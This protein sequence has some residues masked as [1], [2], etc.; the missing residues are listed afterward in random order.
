MR[1]A[2]VAFMMPYH[3]APTVPRRCQVRRFARVALFQRS[4]CLPVRSSI[5]GDVLVR[6]RL[7]VHLDAWSRLRHAQC[8]CF[9][10]FRSVSILTLAC[11]S[12]DTLS[13]CA[14]FQGVSCLCQSGHKAVAVLTRRKVLRF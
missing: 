9:V 11:V 13:E 14:C 3:D 6:A 4:T 7:R 12:I 8:A 1:C 10:G 5:L 2:F